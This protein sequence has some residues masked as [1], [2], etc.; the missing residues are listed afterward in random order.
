M[1]ISYAFAVHALGNV[2]RALASDS[3][4]YP[5]AAYLP[6]LEMFSTEMLA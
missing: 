4:A 2:L 6:R 1:T 5:L 3:A